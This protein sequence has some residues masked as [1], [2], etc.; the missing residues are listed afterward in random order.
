VIVPTAFE[1]SVK[2]TTLVRSVS[3]ASKEDVLVADVDPSH[4]G[5]GVLGGEQPRPHV[6][7]VVEPGHD[8][9]VAGPERP[10]D[11]SRDREEQRRRVRAEDHLV[12]VRAQQVRGRSVRLEEEVVGLLARDERA[13]GVRVAPA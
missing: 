9:L 6:R 13:V 8:H 2:A 5:P 7:I 1:A 10:P 4:G 12:R 3:A 11:R